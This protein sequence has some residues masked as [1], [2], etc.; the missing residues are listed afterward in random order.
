[1]FVVPSTVQLVV[2]ITLA[3]LGV[4]GNLVIPFI[5]YRTNLR[6]SHIILLAALDLTATLLGPG[7]M[8]VIHVIGPSWLENSKSLCHALTFLTTWQ[9]ITCF[10]VLFVLAVFCQKVRHYVQSVEKRRARRRQI[11]VLAVC[12]LMAVVLSVVPLL[13]WSSY[14]GLYFIHSCALPRPTQISHY[15]I[16]YLAFSFALLLTSIFLAAKALKKRRFY[17]L[18]LY[19]ERHVLETKMNDPEMTTA[20]SSSTS[21]RSG[22]FSSG[23]F[24][25]RRSVL[26]SACNSPMVGRK[27]SQKSLPLEGALNTLLEII[28]RQNERAHAQQTEPGS[29]Q[30]VQLQASQSAS[31]VLRSPQHGTPKGP[32]VI[33]YRVPDINYKRKKIFE[34]PRWLPLSKAPKEQRSL[35]RLLMLRCCVTLICCLPLYVTAA[36]QMA[37]LQYPQELNVLIQWLVFIQSSVSPMLLLCDVSYRQIWSRIALSIFK[38]CIQ[39]NETHGDLEKSRDVDCRMEETQ[40]VRLKEMFPLDASRLWRNA[41]IYYEI[42]T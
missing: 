32:F 28:A 14:D 40:Q 27:A 18:Q 41:K 3:L 25:T 22:R 38:I 7:I 17:P 42:K 39:S 31:V 29:S 19:W 12:F 24:A 4:C 6:C 15:S 34:S 16:C 13:G 11:A 30:E 2:A 26:P 21:V 10:L 1:M 36:L 8:L 5:S 37:A 33:S 35:S 20:A 9:L 23:S